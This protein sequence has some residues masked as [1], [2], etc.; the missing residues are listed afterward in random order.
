MI[1]KFKPITA[2]NNTA[3]T[4][5]FGAVSYAYYISECPI[6]NSLY[7]EFLNDSKYNEIILKKYKNHNNEILFKNNIYQPKNKITEYKP[8]T[9][10]SYYDANNFIKWLNNIDR[11]NQYTLPSTHEWYKAAY[12]DPVTQQYSNFPNRQNTILEHTKDPTSEYGLNTNN[13]FGQ[14]VKN[15]FFVMNYSFFDVR[16]C[17]DN[18]YEF[19]RCPL[20]SVKVGSC[21]I[22]GCGWNRNIQNAHKDRYCLRK[23]SKLFYSNYIGFRVCK[24]IK[25]KIFYISLHNTFGDGWKGGYINIYDTN[26]GIIRS[27]ITLKNG[28]KSQLVRLQLY[29]ITDN[30]IIIKY[31][32]KNNLYYENSIQIYNSSKNPIC[33]YTINKNNFTKVID[34]VD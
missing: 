9:D 13:I 5:N 26:Y 1:I 31:I 29:N 10:I 3:D 30:Y 25:P 2:I 24:Q 19:I 11:K 14:T 34:I 23:V 4:N 33:Q 16:D 28:H 7:C 18:V 17:A 8:V 12:Y 27:N 22:V 20:A 32:P 6:S 15:K 21:N